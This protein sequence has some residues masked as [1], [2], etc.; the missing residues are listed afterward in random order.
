MDGGWWSIRQ[1]RGAASAQFS[2]DSNMKS[3]HLIVA[4]AL[5]LAACGSTSKS[6]VQATMTEPVVEVQGPFVE[7]AP[8]VERAQPVVRDPLSSP[9]VLDP[10]ARIDAGCDADARALGLFREFGLTSTCIGSATVQQL[11]QVASAL[12]SQDKAALVSMCNPDAPQAFV[13]PRGTWLE[14]VATGTETM[15]FGGEELEVELLTCEVV[16]AP[17]DRHVGHTVTMPIGWIQGRIVVE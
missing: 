4:F 2:I 1:G 16:A 17:E 10:L 3:I 14:V 5:P 6:S 11:P 8:Q 7:A 15:H 9:V 13:M 12:V